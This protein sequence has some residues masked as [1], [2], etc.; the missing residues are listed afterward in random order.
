MVIPFSFLNFVVFPPLQDCKTLW[1]LNSW[2]VWWLSSGMIAPRISSTLPAWF[3]AQPMILKARLAP[4]VV[5]HKDV[6]CGSVLGR[7][8]LW[9]MFKMVDTTA[10][11]TTT[12][13]CSPQRAA[14]HHNQSQVRA[15]ESLWP[16]TRKTGSAEVIFCPSFYVFTGWQTYRLRGQERTH[17]SRVAI[18]R[19]LSSHVCTGR[20]LL[21]ARHRSYRTAS[22][23]ERKREA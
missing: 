4:S 22:K 20:V 16:H 17:S 2:L 5:L 23:F 9:Q 1:W 7:A 13:R 8:A 14:S 12:R 11:H 6:C 18:A 10:H 15:K 3:S 21:C 19:P